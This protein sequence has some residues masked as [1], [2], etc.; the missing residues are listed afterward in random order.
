MHISFRIAGSIMFEG[1]GHNRADVT[2]RAF[3]FDEILTK[4][5]VLTNPL[6]PHFAVPLLTRRGHRSGR[7]SAG[8]RIG[9][10]LFH[11]GSTQVGPKQLWA[12]AWSVWAG[13]NAVVPVEC[14]PNRPYRDLPGE[15]VSVL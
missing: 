11:T 2:S 15:V 8:R 4:S 6:V 5:S 14:E 12:R 7:I 13:L 3:D 10:L 1:F 9:A